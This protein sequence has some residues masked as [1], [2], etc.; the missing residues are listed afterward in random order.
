M[1]EADYRPA[2]SHGISEAMLQTPP[3]DALANERDATSESRQ[4]KEEVDSLI[5]EYSDE[6]AADL[7]PIAAS[8]IALVASTPAPVKVNSWMQDDKRRARA[9]ENAWPDS[10]GTVRSYRAPTAAAA[11]T[12]APKKAK[13]QSPAK[14]KSWMRYNKRRARAHAN[15]WPDSDGTVR[16]LRPRSRWRIRW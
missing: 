3:D 15:A 12:P 4:D 7:V 5:Q 14:V 8:A 2:I 10:D 6:V 1:A 9:H 16:S 13:Q 11:S